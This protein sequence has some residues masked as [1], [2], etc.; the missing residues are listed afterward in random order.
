MTASGARGTCRVWAH[1]QAGVRDVWYG[2]PGVPQASS[3]RAM[4]T[5]QHSAR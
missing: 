5:Q 1:C 3:G 2:R 4:G